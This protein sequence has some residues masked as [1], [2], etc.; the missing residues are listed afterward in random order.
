MKRTKV[1]CKN[2]SKLISRSNIG[3]HENACINGYKKPKSSID[4]NTLQLLANDNYVCPYC[5]KEFSKNKI[6]IHVKTSHLGIQK[7]K[8][9]YKVEWNTWNKGLT[10]ETDG[11]VKQNGQTY[12]DNLKSGKTQHYINPNRDD[13][14]K[15]KFLCRFK[16]N[17]YDEF[18]HMVEDIE[19]IGWYTPPT[20][21]NNYQGNVDGLSRDHIISIKFG[22]ENNILP[23]YISHPANCDIITQKE[24]SKKREK[25]GMTVDDLIEAVGQITIIG[26]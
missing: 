20:K 9:Q 18:K 17:I 13:M 10:K 8:P 21:K 22:F 12:K 6:G 3:R 26:V 1:E 2:C 23:Y 24:N 14:E 25:C 5:F 4:F 15:Y 19:K 11:R 7:Q 16:F